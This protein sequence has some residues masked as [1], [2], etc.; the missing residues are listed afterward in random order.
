MRSG[1]Y[2]QTP[3]H[4]QQEALNESIERTRAVMEQMKGMPN[5]ETAIM[6]LLQN[7]PQLGNIATMVRNGQSLEGIAKSM[8][9]AGGYD[10]NQIIN[11]LQGGK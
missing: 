1:A 2:P 5:M 10:I 3:Q 4:Q 11:R 9:Q 7:N 8:A 6:N